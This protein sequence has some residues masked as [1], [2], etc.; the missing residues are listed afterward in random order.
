MFNQQRQV[1]LRLN[2]MSKEHDNTSSQYIQTAMSQAQYEILSDDGSYYGEIPNFQGVY[3]NAETLD[4]CQSK[5]AEV[6]QEWIAFRVPRNLDLPI[7][8]V[9]QD[10]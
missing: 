6:L 4:K 9:G 8:G 5:L 2:I 10:N 1:F 3:A 7:I